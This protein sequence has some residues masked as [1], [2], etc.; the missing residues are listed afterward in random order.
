MREYVILSKYLVAIYEYRYEKVS[1]I[2]YAIIIY[3]IYINLIANIF[4]AL[5]Y[6]ELSIDNSSTRY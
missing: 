5:R 1:L 4:Y 6:K 2:L 3:K